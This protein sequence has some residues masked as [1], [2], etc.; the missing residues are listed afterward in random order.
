MLTY[1]DNQQSVG[2]HSE[3]GGRER[4]VSSS[5]AMLFSRQ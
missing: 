2:P 5:Q 3:A 4:R 1:L